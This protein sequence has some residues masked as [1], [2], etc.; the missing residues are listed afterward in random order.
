MAEKR[1]GKERVKK[2]PVDLRDIYYEPTLRE[3]PRELDNWRKVPWV[4][5]QQS[6][7]AC[8]GFA[9]AAVVNYLLGNRSDRGRSK[10]DR[11]SP[12]MLYEMARRYDEWEGEHYEGS[13]I[14]G[15]MKG[16]F[17]HGVCTEKLWPY[18]PKHA[19]RIS[20]DAALDARRRPLGA[21]YRV[22]HRRLNHMH[23]A[24]GEAGI[25]L[26]SSAVHAG[27]DEVGDDGFVPYRREDR[28]GHAFAI[29]G[30]DETGFWIQN[31]WGEDWGFWGFGHLSYD[32]WL[33]NGWDCWVARTGVPIVSVTRGEASVRERARFDYLPYTEVDSADIS[34]HLVH[35]GDDG[36]LEER[37]RFAN[38]AQDVHELVHRRFA[39]TTAAWGRRRLLLY[40]HGGLNSAKDSAS[41]IA[42]MKSYF[43]ANEIYPVHFMWESGIVEST[44]GAV[45]YAL[46]SR[47][48]AGIGDRFADLLDEAIELGARPLGKPLW[49]EMKRNARL[50]SDGGGGA[51][52]FV[53]ELRQW[54]AANGPIELHLVGHSAGSVF[55]AYLMK[56]LV[57]A[58]IPVKSLTL[59]A[60]ACT[61]AL[62]RENVIDLADHID[63]MAV[64]NLD[65]EAE[66]DDNVGPYRKSLLYLVSES[67]ETRRHESLL[68]V[69]KHLVGDAEIRRFFGSVEDAGPATRVHAR[70]MALSRSLRSHATR[71]AEFDSDEHTLNATLRIILGRRPARPF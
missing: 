13:S 18:D 49:G 1:H 60:P 47:R 40:A 21:Y 20:P 16:W 48:A 6:E 17:N 8:V 68:G 62:F 63:R 23:D 9:S 12:R 54:I 69:E 59:F 46:G 34:G 28:G 41:R 55:H 10:P 7:G 19:G 58:G 61:T 57:A 4:L 25:L 27:W 65:D 14:R 33:E 56:Q 39:R 52:L 36:R 22:H 2:D 3:L 66:R 26:A 11:V 45:R 30:Y 35:C 64:F 67:F 50:A 29:I 51:A 44:L 70:G 5:D 31:S 38:D 15:A 37:G 42:S 53:S 24:V 71:H 32:D 43:L